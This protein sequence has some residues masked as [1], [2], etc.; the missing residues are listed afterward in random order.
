LQ[1]ADVFIQK[2]GRLVSNPAQ[3]GKET[4]ASDAAKDQDGFAP[5]YA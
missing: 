2:F 3:G 5:P 1:K 4:N